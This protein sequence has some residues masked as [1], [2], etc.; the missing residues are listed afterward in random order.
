M[1]PGLGIAI[2]ASL[3]MT[4]TAGDSATATI[5][6]VNVQSSSFNPSNLTIQQGDTVKWQ[7]ISGFHTTTSG[8]PAG[9]ADGT[10]DALMDPSNQSFQRQFNSAGSF[11]YFCKF[12][13]AS[14]MTANLTVELS[15]GVFDGPSSE[16]LPRSFAL[17]QNYP[18]PFNAG[19]VISYVLARDGHTTLQVFDVLGRTVTILVDEM[20]PMGRHRLSWDGRD[21]RGLPVASGVYFYRLTTGRDIE[22]RTMILLK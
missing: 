4:I 1:K 12:H 21:E 2:L 16:N 5:W 11:P 3:V 15:T 20:Q 8:E 7:W 14:G 10:W 17:E 13:W 22:S 18:N 9:T 6:T 19:T